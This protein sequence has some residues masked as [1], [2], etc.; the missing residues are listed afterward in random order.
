MLMKKKKTTILSERA[1]LANLTIS[2]WGARRF[3]DGVADE[4]L[5][6][7]KA[8]KDVGLF[9]KRLLNKAAMAKL[10]QVS[11]QARIY[12]NRH[13]QPWLDDGVRILATTMFLDYSAE[14]SKYKN[15]FDAAV[16]EF[17][18]Q[19]PKYIEEAKK[20]LGDL[21]D[22][23]DYPKASDIK[24]R[25]AWHLHI[26]PCPNSEDFRVDLAD[27]QME[28]IKRDLDATLES[29]VKSAL[30]DTARRLAEMIG[31]MAEKLK[32]YKP[33]NKKSGAKATNQFRDSLVD[34]IRELAELLPSF[35]LDDDP[36][37]EKLT[38]RIKEE[39]CQHD[40]AVLREDD[41]VRKEVRASAEE[42]LKQVNDFMA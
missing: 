28:A 14:M 9:T 18:S 19:Y 41:A 12:H 20:E 16:N 42:I 15:A 37:F 38:K 33:A 32:E 40:A 23:H 26:L 30:K 1:V 4:V 6:E 8:E 39:L 36:D 31:H 24:R 3:D 10:R 5:K 35:N 34:N 25:F 27:E 2:R 11:D 17:V 13:T 29:Q 21:F 22:E 7:K